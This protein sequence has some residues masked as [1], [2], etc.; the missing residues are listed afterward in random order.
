MAA[1]FHY[2]FCITC[3]PFFCSTSPSKPLQPIPIINSHCLK[4]LEQFLFPHPTMINA[5]V[6]FQTF[7]FPS[8]GNLL[9]PVLLQVFL[10][11]AYSLIFLKILF[12]HN[13]YP[14]ILTN[15]RL[16]LPP[17]HLSLSP[18]G[19]NREGEKNASLLL[20]KGKYKIRK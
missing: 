11:I 13:S 4:H 10:L 12:L 7:Q 6:H 17:L 2:S 19:E 14:L 8:D 16:P 3:P 18:S 1:V 20:Q 9:F 5:E 15:T